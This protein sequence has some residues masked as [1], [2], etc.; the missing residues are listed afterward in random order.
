MDGIDWKARALAAEE[1]LATQVKITAEVL[2]R[3]QLT[4]EVLRSFQSNRCY[5][6]N[7]PLKAT[8]QYGCTPFNCSMRPQESW[9]LY[10]SWKKRFDELEQIHAALSAAQGKE[11]G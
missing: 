4:Y 11:Q 10:E 8:I 7:W 1:S 3:Q 5:A 2:E 9:P 6:C